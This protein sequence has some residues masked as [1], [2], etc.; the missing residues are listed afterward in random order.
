MT[1]RVD[2]AG[3]PFWYDGNPNDLRQ[4]QKARGHRG[5]HQWNGTDGFY[6]K[7]AEKPIEEGV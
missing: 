1:Y 3:C 2:S 5:E 7:W 6:V 4:C